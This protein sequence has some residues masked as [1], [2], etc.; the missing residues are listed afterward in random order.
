VVEPLVTVVHGQHLVGI[1]PGESVAI[2]G[3]GGPIGLMHLQLALRA[4][5]AQVMAIGHS[6]PRLRVAQALG[7]TA[8]VNAH[9]QDTVTAVRRLTDGYGADVVIECAG[10]KLAWET[11]IEAVRKGGRV[12]WFGG[13]P[14]G[15]KIELEAGRIHYGEIALINMHGGT[16]LEARE[17]FDLIAS[18]AVNVQ[19][20]LSGELPLEQVETALTG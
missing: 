2:L 18:G 20:L 1:R 11:A 12:L 6:R 5:A 7:A 16:A 15:T 10:T 8:V 19:A 4:G 3:A 9:E 17:A 13:L 14:A